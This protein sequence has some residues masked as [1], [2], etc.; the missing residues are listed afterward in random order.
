MFKQ[1]SLIDLRFIENEDDS[2]IEDDEICIGFHLTK[3]EGRE[4][5]IL[6]YS[7]REK[8]CVII[9]HRKI[10]CRF[11]TL[12]SI[13]AEINKIKNVIEEF[14]LKEEKNKL[15]KELGLLKI[16]YKTL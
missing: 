14:I 10:A 4:S 5:K 16:K 6:I 1:I 9:G 12:P 3:E 2:W 7:Y 11:V 8:D 13:H 15:K